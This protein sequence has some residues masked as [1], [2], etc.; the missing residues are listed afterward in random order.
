[1][2]LVLCILFFW[3]QDNSQKI[4]KTLEMESRRGDLYSLDLP[5]SKLV[6]LIIQKRLRKLFRM[7]DLGILSLD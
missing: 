3:F 5:K 7:L 4:R 2:T 6:L 1:M